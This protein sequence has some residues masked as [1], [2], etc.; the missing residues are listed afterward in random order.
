MKRFVE[1]EIKVTKFEY[2]NL[3][4]DVIIDGSVPNVGGGEIT[5]EI[6]LWGE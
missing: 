3:M 1:P 6:S 4:D 2:E 5:E